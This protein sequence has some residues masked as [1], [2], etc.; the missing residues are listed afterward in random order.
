VRV[1]IYL[2]KHLPM[3]VCASYSSIR[4]RAVVNM[5]TRIYGA[6]EE[7][8]VEWPV[9]IQIKGMEDKQTRI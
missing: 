8:I 1:Y 2:P 9:L 7:L 5:L 3:Y 4:V 6:K